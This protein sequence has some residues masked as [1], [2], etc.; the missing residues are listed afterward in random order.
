[1]FLKTPQG[2]VLLLCEKPGQSCPCTSAHTSWIQRSGSAPL[3]LTLLAPCA[4]CS[5]PVFTAAF[6]LTPLLSSADL[7]FQPVCT[8]EPWRLNTVFFPSYPHPSHTDFPLFQ[9]IVTCEQS[10]TIVENL[11]LG[12]TC[13][14]RRA[15]SRPGV[16]SSSEK[17]LR[18]VRSMAADVAVSEWLRPWAMHSLALDWRGSCRL[19][20]TISDFAGCALPCLSQEFLKPLSVK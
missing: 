11:T 3:A 2:P 16:S 20:L 8:Q 4:G 5:C 19:A 1:M 14:W 9:R 7:N 17:H 12:F 13:N 10:P 18:A 6:T 15:E